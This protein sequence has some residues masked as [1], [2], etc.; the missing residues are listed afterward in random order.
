MT[1]EFV[2]VCFNVFIMGEPRGYVTLKGWCS[3]N[4]LPTVLRKYV[5]D[6]MVSWLLK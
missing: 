6:G 1:N 5:G 4:K 3:L 2:Q